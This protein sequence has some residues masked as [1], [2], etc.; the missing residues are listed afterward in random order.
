MC[1]KKKNETVIMEQ[2]DNYERGEDAMDREIKEEEKINHTHEM[3]M[4]MMMIIIIII[5]IRMEMDA[6]LKPRALSA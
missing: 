2:G 6:R 4:M 5:I 1:K 3:M